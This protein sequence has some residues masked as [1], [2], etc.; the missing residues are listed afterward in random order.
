MLKELI[1]EG[2]PGAARYVKEVK[3]ER[4]STEDRLNK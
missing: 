1:V 4:L 2:L 3:V